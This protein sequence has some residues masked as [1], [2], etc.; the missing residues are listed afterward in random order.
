MGVISSL[1]DATV[2]GSFFLVSA[3]KAN[4]DP[5]RLPDAPVDAGQAALV[6][7]EVVYATSPGEL[8][9]F[10]YR[11]P[12]PAP[13]PAVIFEHGSEADPGDML[14]EAQ[15]FVPHGFVMFAPHRR[16]QG[17]SA[18]AGEYI[19]RASIREGRQPDQ[20]VEL[21][22]AQVDDVAAAV[23]YVRRLPDV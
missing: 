15:F 14:D 7:R 20:L 13:F 18:G 3:C 12:G 10:L 5:S 4:A 2:V 23:A 19:N 22:D 16:G 8:R 21:L 1:R 17:R 6:S 11:P 9:G